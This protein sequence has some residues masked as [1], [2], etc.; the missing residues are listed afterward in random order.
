MNVSALRAYM[1][2][3]GLDAVIVTGE[4][5]QRYLL[6]Y[7]FT[8]GL[9]LIVQDE[10][11]MITDFRYEEEAK[12]H[13]D[14]AFTVV[15]PTL[16]GAF[17]TE[18]LEHAR[19]H[20]I[21]YE[22]QTMTVA[23]HEAY[24]KKYAAYTF[25]PLGSAIEEL[26]QIKTPAEIALMQKAQDI[27]DG[28]FAAL[29]GR[30]TPQMTELEVAYELEYQMRRLGADGFAF[31]TIAVSGDAS[32]LPHGH[33]RNERL[34]AGFLTMDFGAQYNGY[35]S[36]MTRTVVIGRADADMRRLYRTVSEAQ[37][38]GI[39]AI[40]AGA[41][42]AETDAAARDLIE[43]AGYHNC[44]GHSL[45]HG[46]GLFIHEEPRLSSR[47]GGK[48][49]RAGQVVTAEPGI[50]ISGQYGCRIEDM[51]LVTEDGSRNFTHSPKDLIE[52]L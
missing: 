25:L 38:A 12:K 34:H 32:A 7:P 42:C 15:C 20:T 41:D 24:K 4:R 19:A 27:T 13:A 10:A 17:I 37:L 47:A 30:L 9:L 33:P 31:E 46:V 16:R 52:I 28:A 35:C 51:L 40:R 45:G 36:D 14:P 49:L 22:D 11:Y 3:H 6:D 2:A 26:R 50:Y 48:C 21:G 23:E 1:S 5:N 44:F 39:A 43:A 8:D 29:L 18:V